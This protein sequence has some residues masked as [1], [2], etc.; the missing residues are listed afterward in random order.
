MSTPLKFYIQELKD[1]IQRLKEL[2][3]Q[4][5]RDIE[6]EDEKQDPDGLDHIPQDLT[7]E[8]VEGLAKREEKK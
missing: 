7:E 6:L 5:G 2:R 1:D 3:E 4:L 8:E